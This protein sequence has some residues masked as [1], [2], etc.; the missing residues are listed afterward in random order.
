[1]R[2]QHVITQKDLISAHVILDT[3]VMDFRAVVKINAPHEYKTSNDHKNHLQVMRNL[4]F[5]CYLDTN[6][7]LPVSACDTNA[8][9]N[10]I[11]GSYTCTCDP[12]Y[13]GDGLTCNGM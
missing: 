9:C 5:L 10:N 2:M 8:V 4:I 3:V 6:E 7:C 11:E 12:G 13:S 1:M